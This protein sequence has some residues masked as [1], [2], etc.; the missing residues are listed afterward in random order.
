MLYSAGMA[1]PDQSLLGDIVDR[2]RKMRY[3]DDALREHTFSSPEDKALAMAGGAGARAYNA[4]GNAGADIVNAY[5]PRD[6]SDRLAGQTMGRSL[7][8]QIGEAARKNPGAATTGNLAVT[9]PLRTAATLAAG[10]LSVPG[11]AL[12]QGLVGGAEGAFSSEEGN[13][14]QGAAHNAAQSAALPLAVGGARAL[15]SLADMS[16]PSGGAP[17]VAEAGGASVSRKVPGKPTEKAQINYAKPEGG[18]VAVEAKQTVRPG[19]RSAAAAKDT[20]APERPAM[21]PPSSAE[22]ESVTVPKAGKLPGPVSVT[23]P[24]G[25]GAEMPHV[26]SRSVPPEADAASKKWMDA[27]VKQQI[28]E[29][30]DAAFGGE[31]TPLPPSPGR[32][33][34]PGRLPAEAHFEQSY[35]PSEFEGDVVGAPSKFQWTPLEE[36]Y[37]RAQDAKNVDRLIGGG[38][39]DIYR[40]PE[41]TEKLRQMLRELGQPELGTSKPP[42]APPPPK[43]PTGAPKDEEDFGGL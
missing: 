38:S 23:P 40:S 32:L 8:T 25:G 14:M 34:G 21:R 36:E 43:R 10:P 1:D 9:A 7:G 33:P 41:D 20:V 30:L 37:A 39:R 12:L 22:A 19:A 13:R 15:G 28:D 11:E 31:P 27:R 6:S 16:P 17:A 18:P 5:A 26:P 24:A 4:L 42:S 35:R 2:L 29:G 3:G